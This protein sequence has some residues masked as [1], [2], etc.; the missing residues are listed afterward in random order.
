MPLAVLDSIHI[1]FT[2]QGTPS[3]ESTSGSTSTGRGGGTQSYPLKDFA[4]VGVRDGAFLVTCYDAEVRSPST[5]TA[6]CVC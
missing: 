1:T 2:P 5:K 4:S 6:E 3:G